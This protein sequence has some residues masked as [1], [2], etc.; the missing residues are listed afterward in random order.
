M[1]RITSGVCQCEASL[2]ACASG[3][4]LAIFGVAFVLLG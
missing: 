1:E 4:A 2:L 3:I